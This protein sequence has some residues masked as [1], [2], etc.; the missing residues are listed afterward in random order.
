MQN[1]YLY[2]KYKI[3]TMKKNTLI[4]L[5]ASFSFSLFAQ[6]SIDITNRYPFDRENEMVEVKASEIGTLSANLILKD[7]SG[8]EVPYQLLYNG[9]TTPQAIVFPV[10]V[11]TGT[12]VT[13]T[14]SPGTPAPVA[15]RTMARL[16]PERK[17]DFAW[18]NDFAGYRMYGPAIAA[19]NPSNG[20]DLWLKKS[21]ELV[22]DTLYHW[23]LKLGKS[24]HED[25]GLGLD[26][27]KVGATLGAGGVT[28]YTDSTLWIGKHFDRHRVIENGPLRSVFELIYDKV[29]IKGQSYKKTLTIT[30]DAGMV[31]NKAVVK[32]EGPKQPMQMAAGFTL[33]DGKG[34]LQKGTGLIVY[35]EDAVSDAGV[36]QGKNYVGIVLPERE[37]DYK[38]QNLH[39]LL[40]TD[41]TV[42]TEFTYY[43]GGGWSEWKFPTQRDWLAAVQQFSRLARYPLTIQ[44]VK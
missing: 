6:I 3:S 5:L 30:T 13:Y 40:L 10:N 44:V 42:G 7:D 31:M 18:E 36:A 34:Q 19:E 14:L 38:I 16:V 8:N 43:F 28:A 35:G 27:Y 37:N 33:H 24:Y 20:I 2:V 39:A 17:D 4:L 21:E 41:Y 23:E 11:K 9:K 25:H 26:C 29:E 1:R 22:M 12:K 15:A 32:L